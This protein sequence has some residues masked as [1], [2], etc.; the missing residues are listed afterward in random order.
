ML[1]TVSHCGVVSPFCR[2]VGWWSLRGVVLVY[3]FWWRIIPVSTSLSLMGGL[4]LVLIIARQDPLGFHFAA[5]VNHCVWLLIHTHLLNY[6]GVIV[7][8]SV[9]SST[10]LSWKGLSKWLFLLSL[11]CCTHHVL[12]IWN[13]LPNTIDSTLVLNQLS[14][15]LLVDRLVHKMWPL[16]VSLG[17]L[18]DFYCLIAW[19]FRRLL[20]L[21]CSTRVSSWARAALTNQEACFWNVIV[22]KT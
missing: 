2:L 11:V 8:W 21:W 6:S 19:V 12:T 10:H 5:M 16:S 22:H 18:T 20:V 7:V 1:H 4:R 17:S 9:H 3:L 14:K 15:C 13:L